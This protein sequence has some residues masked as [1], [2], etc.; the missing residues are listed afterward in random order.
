[1]SAQLLDYEVL[2]AIGDDTNPTNVGNCHRIRSRITGKLFVWKAINYASP[3]PE[4]ATTTPTTNALPL[5][6]RQLVADIQRLKQ[7]VHPNIVRYYKHIDHVDTAR[8]Y[9][10][11]ECCDG[12]SLSSL[13]GKCRRQRQ[14]IE[15]SFVWR[16]VVQLCRAVQQCELAFADGDEVGRRLLARLRENVRRPSSVLLDA[17]GNVKL[18]ASGLNDGDAD[19]TGVH[20]DVVRSLGCVLYE[21]CTLRCP[22]IDGVPTRIPGQY[23]DDLQGIIA[24]MLSQTN[25][26]ESRPTVTSILHHPLVVAKLT[27]GDIT[28]G[29]FPAL[30]PSTSAGWFSPAEDLSSTRIGESLGIGAPLSFADEPTSVLRRQLFHQSHMTA[31]DDGTRSEPSIFQPHHECKLTTET[32][33]KK[34]CSD[35]LINDHHHQHHH[36]RHG[37]SSAL[38]SDPNEITEG[39]F[40]EAFRQRLVTI[41]QRE[42]ELRQHETELRQREEA[43][44]MR[45]MCLGQHLPSRPK[46]LQADDHPND[47]DANDITGITVEPNETCHSLRAQPTVALIDENVIRRPESFARSKLAIA[48]G[49]RPRSLFINVESPTSQN[50]MPMPPPL[51]PRNHCH[52]RHSKAYSQQDLAAAVTNALAELA[53]G[54]EE[55]RR[56][57]QHQRRQPSKPLR[58][59]TASSYSASSSSASSVQTKSASADIPGCWTNDTKRTAFAMLAAMN[60]NSQRPPM[61]L[62]RRRMSKADGCAAADRTIVEE[63]LV[64]DRLVRHDRKRQSMMVVMAPPMTA[65]AIVNENRGQRQHSKQ[66]GPLMTML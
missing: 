51:P 31:S 17:S 36:H 1:M 40:K 37:P 54:G 24:L 47:S 65:S 14:H 12:D 16:C 8:L 62:D 48:A 30:L 26:I 9:V 22:P 58:T 52:R 28:D 59:S 64:N 46:D 49:E 38:R 10:I 19:E 7:L 39:V 18:N 42:A 25:A 35:G 6:I 5:H 63:M 34:A 43:V 20:F 41:R 3:L 56:E 61:M 55:Q 60:A 2:A 21:L 66:M 13:I 32:L 53:E 44:R 15:E 33:L 23:S 57:K 11:M 27:N 4:N 50:G 29:A 45:E